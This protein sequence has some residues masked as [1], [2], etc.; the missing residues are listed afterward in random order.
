MKKKVLLVIT[1]LA[2]LCLTTGCMTVSGSSLESMFGSGKSG[3]VNVSGDSPAASDGDTVTISREEYERLAK[4]SDLA[5]LYDAAEYYFYQE[6]DS[7]KLL[8]YAARG[9]MAGLDD[10][11]SFYYSPEEYAQMF[12]DDEGKYGGIGVMILGDGNTNTC[13]ITRVFKNSPAEKVGIQRG[14]VLYRVED[15]L[16]VTAENLN[17]AVSI[18]RGDPGEAVNVTFLRDGEEITF[19][20][21]REEVNVNQ[22][23]STMREPDIGYIAM[24]QFAG[25]A[26][27]EFEKALNELIDQGAKGI[28]IDLRDNTGGW[29]EQAR[30]IADL[31]M[32]AGELCYLVDRSGTEEHWWYPTKDGKVDVEIVVLVNEMSASSSEILTGALKDCSGATVVGTNT[33]GKGIVQNIFSLGTNGAGF[34]I[35]IA[36]YYSPKGNKVHQVGIA[37]DVEVERPEGDNGTY[38]FADPEKDIQLQ[39]AIEVMRDKL[40]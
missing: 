39:K 24:Y 8:E 15:D 11:Y 31:F 35:T 5:D 4:F 3:K 23:E 30:Y 16:Y 36:E 13:V 33:F 20:I 40:N 21:V 17:E 6:P 38:D 10:P 37:P 26:E 2:V 28:I 32:D 18:M 27:K 12:E 14:D 19:N 29:V 25:E 9:L 22:V 34:Q 7:D 1:L